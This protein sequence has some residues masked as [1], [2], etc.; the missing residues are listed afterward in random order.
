MGSF[1]ERGPERRV[2][3]GSGDEFEQISRHAGFEVLRGLWGRCPRS[4]WLYGSEAGHMT[5][6]NPSRCY[7]LW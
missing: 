7:H 6:R 1:A 2:D 4:R 3:L 5:S